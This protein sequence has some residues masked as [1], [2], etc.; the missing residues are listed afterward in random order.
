MPVSQ[1]PE[2]MPLYV[3]SITPALAAEVA[4]SAKATTEAERMVFMFRDVLQ[5][6]KGKRNVTGFLW[7]WR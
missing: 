2:A 7:P 1:L 4:M 3:I 5:S 6:V